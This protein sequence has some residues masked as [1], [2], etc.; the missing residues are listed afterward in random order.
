MNYGRGA[1]LNYVICIRCPYAIIY[2]VI[3]RA[4]KAIYLSHFASFHFIC[5]NNYI[6]NYYTHFQNKQCGIYVHKNNVQKVQKKLATTCIV[7]PENG[8]NSLKNELYASKT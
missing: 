7:L 1:P 8:K 5:P 2:V 6:T 4:K 3:V